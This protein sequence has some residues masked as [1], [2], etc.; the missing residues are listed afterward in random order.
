MFGSLNFN[1]NVDVS[2]FETVI[3]L[4]GGLVSCYD[5]SG[6]SM[7]LEK[8]QD[9]ADRLLPNFRPTGSGALGGRLCGGVVGGGVGCGV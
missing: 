8:A 1:K 3:R 7:F 5:L 4:L 9:L 6:D 2:F